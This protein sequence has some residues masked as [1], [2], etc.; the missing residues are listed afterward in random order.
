MGLIGA[1]QAGAIFNPAKEDGQK[2]A[3]TLVESVILDGLSQRGIGGQ[4]R[5]IAHI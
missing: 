5:G 3:M 4:K 1:K 2:E